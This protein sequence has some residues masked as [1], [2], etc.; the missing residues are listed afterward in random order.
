M[1]Q[2]TPPSPPQSRERVQRVPYI[3]GDWYM[4]GDAAKPCRI[5]QRRGSD[6]A[7]FINE[8]GS[9]AE[10]SIRGDRVFIPD[11]GDNGQGLEGVIRSDRI[12]WLP[13]RSYWSCS[14]R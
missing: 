14:S 13:D 12:I 8:H 5:V 6:R 11:W 7:R 9:E 10:G 4:W 1:L 2:S 3:G